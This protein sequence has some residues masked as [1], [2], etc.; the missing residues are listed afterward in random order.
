MAQE[1]KT[2]KMKERKGKKDRKKERMKD[3]ASEVT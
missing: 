1:Q 3:Y 2:N